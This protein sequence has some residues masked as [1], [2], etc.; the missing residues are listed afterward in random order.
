M[1]KCSVKIV[2]HNSI[3]IPTAVIAPYP[4]KSGGLLISKNIN[5][6]FGQWCCDY[7]W[8]YGTYHQGG[9][10]TQYNRKQYIITKKL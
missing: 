9:K 2:K 1:S 10:K 4:I 8:S 3:H 5:L 7:T 6:M